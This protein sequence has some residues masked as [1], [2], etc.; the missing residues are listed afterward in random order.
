LQWPADTAYKLHIE[1]CIFTGNTLGIEW[2]PVLSTKIIISQLYI[3][4]TVPITI[5][6][7]AFSDNIFQN[8]KT[9]TLEGSIEQLKNKC[10][11]GLHNLDTLEISGGLIQYVAGGILKDVQNLLTL[12]IESGINDDHLNYFLQNITLHNLQQLHIRYNNFKTLKSENLRG[13]TNLLT[14]NAERSHITSI[15]STIL[16]SSANK[17]EKVNFAGNELETL[18]VDIFNIKPKTN[19]QVFLQQ[20]KLKTLPEGIFDMAI[21]SIGKVEVHL[22]DN[23]WHCD[24]D[25]AWLQ[26]YIEEEIIDVGQKPP[27]CE[28]P[29]IIKDT[30]LIEADFSDCI[31]TTLPSASSTTT[32]ETTVSSTTETV[33]SETTSPSTTE[34]I[35]D[36]ATSTTDTTTESS[37]T[38]TENMTTNTITTS[39]ELTTETPTSLTELSTHTS[40]STGDTDN[41]TASSTEVTTDTITSST[42]D[43]DSTT[44]SFTE[45]ITDTTTSS[46]EYTYNTITSSTEVTI[47]IIT[48]STE[49]NDST[50]TSFTEVTTDTTI[51]S[52]EVTDNTITSTEL[53]TDTTTSSTEDNDSTTTSFTEVTTDTTTSS[54]EVT[55]NT[56]TSTEL[57]TD[58]NT[59]STEDKGSTTTLFT[60]VT[61][62]TTTLSTKVT[63]NTI[64]SS[65]ELTTDITT[66]STEDNYSTTISSTED[67]DN[68][69]TSTELTTDT[70]SPSTGDIDNTITSSTEVT[71][72]TTT[73]ATEDNDRTTMSFTEVT[74]D[75][76]TSSTDNTDNIT[77]SSTEITI[78]TSTSST[79]DNDN[80]ITSSTEVTTYTTTS[81]TE[82]VYI[83][84]LCYCP[85][86]SSKYMPISTETNSEAS[87][88][89]THAIRDFEIVEDEQLNQIT[90]TIGVHNE[91]ILIWMTR[92]QTNHTDCKYYHCNVGKEHSSHNFTASFSS[93]PNTAYTIC[94][95]DKIS[96]NK[97]TIC[98]LNCRAYTTQPSPPYRAW[99]LNKD[100]GIILLILCFALLVSVIAGAATV[101]YVLLHKPELI[102]GN[103]RVI[104]VNCH[105]NQVIMIMPKGYYENERKCSSHASYNTAS[106]VRPV[107]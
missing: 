64:T 70:T 19:F 52:T 91:H 6:E 24:C 43:N 60:E 76:T 1:N 98:T 5:E 13:L 62:D 29:E 61:T 11:A 94:A 20:N 103:K 51:S 44:T 4:T 86:C 31:T 25:L 80:P 49:N 38:T 78:D 71:P 37:P 95:A 48:S 97:V 68:T 105:T 54:T 18:P 82:E 3:K 69:I 53:T 58:T 106:L 12:Q 39:T 93:D 65:T 33:T 8:I 100:T 85:A 30:L 81:P 99:L 17:I 96:E 83:D 74:T 45:V 27:K 88:L 90:V 92:S 9:L 16:E 14:L 34:T 46:T 23:D 40:S 35:V 87:S 72:D 75:T 89:R 73:S 26:N 2:L 77:A 28:S 10:F 63:D 59:S 47:D 84:V 50:T 107:M 104:V 67:T 7:N 66:S 102:N 101:Y 32:T 42:E 36:S 56:I 79:K 41:T 55:D 22:E 15:E 21:K 57:T